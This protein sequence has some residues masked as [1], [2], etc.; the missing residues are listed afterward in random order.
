MMKGLF[1]G[2][3]LWLFLSEDKYKVILTGLSM[4]KTEY[5][6]VHA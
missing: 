5:L 2:I 1:H 6:D 4:Y 3:N